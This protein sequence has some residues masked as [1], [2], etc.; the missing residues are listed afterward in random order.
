M[1]APPPPEPLAW[2]ERFFGGGCEVAAGVEADSFLL[3]FDILIQKS[4]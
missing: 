2:K 3:L 1:V 4:R